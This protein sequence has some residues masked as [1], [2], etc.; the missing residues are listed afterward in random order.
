MNSFKAILG[1]RWNLPGRTYFSGEVD[2]ALRLNNSVTGSLEGARNNQNPDA[3]VFPGDWYLDKNH[4]VGIGAKLGYLPER[5]SFW[6]KGGS[7]Y[8]IAGIQRLDVTVETAAAGMLSDGTEILG[9]R[10]ENLSVIPWLAGGGI[11]I[12]SDRRRLDLRAIY[13]RYDFD[14]GAGDALMITTPR[15]DYRFKVSGWGVYL[16]YTWSFRLGPSN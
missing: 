1:H 6:S 3:D 8:V 9:K 2:A 10:R 15:V 7:V 5:I 12:G 13:I 16:G 11:E 4:S 14:Y